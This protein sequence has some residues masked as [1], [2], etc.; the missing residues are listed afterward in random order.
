VPETA[1]EQL[2]AETRPWVNPVTPCVL[3]WVL[4]G[5]G[6]LYLGR[7]ARGLAFF[8]VVLLTFVLGLFSGGTSSVADGQQP[9]SYLATFDNLAMGPLDLVARSVSL[10]GLYYRLPPEEIDPRRQAIM[11]RLRE[12]VR[13]ATYEYGSTFLLTAGLMNMLL[14]LDAFDIATGRKD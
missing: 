7:Q 3:A 1:P 13:Y 9:L 2:S 8:I 5:L 10:G 14:I 11:A 4:P 6:H 12:R